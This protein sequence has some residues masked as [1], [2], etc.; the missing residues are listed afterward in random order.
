MVSRLEIP[1]ARIT[2]DPGHGAILR[3]Q[4]SDRCS[5]H[6]YLL[7]VAADVTLNQLFFRLT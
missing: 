2:D 7:C 5:Q 3:K 6:A 4:S 1:A